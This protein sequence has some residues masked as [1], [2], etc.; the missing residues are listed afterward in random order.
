MIS[1]Q[2]QEQKVSNMSQA[3]VAKNLVAGLDP[4]QQ[5]NTK[6]QITNPMSRIDIVIRVF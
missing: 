4:M 6:A 1:I 2:L 5:L 3:D